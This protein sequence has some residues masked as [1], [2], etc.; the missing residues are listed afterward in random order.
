MGRRSDRVRLERWKK[1]ELTRVRRYWAAYLIGTLFMPLAMTTGGLVSFIRHGVFYPDFIAFVFFIGLGVSALTF[2]PLALLAYWWEFS[3]GLRQYRAQMQRLIA[4][5]RVCY[6]CS[7]VALF[8]GRSIQPPRG[9]P[10][11]YRVLTPTMHFIQEDGQTHVY[12]DACYA[13]LKATPASHA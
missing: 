2:G 7:A 1:R 11:P 3:N 5:D 12:C 13:R 8:E 10:D 4:Q 9:M 6:V